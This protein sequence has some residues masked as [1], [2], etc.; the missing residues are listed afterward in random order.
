MGMCGAS[1]APGVVWG[2]VQVPPE[3]RERPCRCI[4]FV[5]KAGE[6]DQRR[7]K[8]RWPWLADPV[9]APQPVNIPKKA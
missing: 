3:I 9:T 5:P 1:Y 2:G 8:E 6:A 4:A 7:G